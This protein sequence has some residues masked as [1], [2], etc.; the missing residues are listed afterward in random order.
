[1][2]EKGCNLWTREARRWL[3][4]ASGAA[5]GHH[6]SEADMKIDRALLFPMRT[7]RSEAV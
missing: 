5:D 7:R 1:M 3:I 4:D 6:T 2:N